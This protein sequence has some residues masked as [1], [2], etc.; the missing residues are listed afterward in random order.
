MNKAITKTHHAPNGDYI[1][2]AWDAG[3]RLAEKWFPNGINTQFGYN[4]DGTLSRVKNRRGYTDA[5]LVSQHDY[6]YDGF[7]NRIQHAETINGV[8]DITDYVYDDLMRLVTSTAGGVTN[9]Y[10]Y[11][12]LNNRTAVLTTDA[13]GATTSVYSIFDAANQ[14]TELRGG[15]A[16]GPLVGGMV[17]DANGSGRVAAQ[18]RGT[19][20]RTPCGCNLAKQCVGGVVTRSATACTGATVTAAAYDFLGRTAQI[21]KTGQPAQSYDYDDQNRRIRKTVGT[22][23]NNYLYQGEDILAEYANGWAAATG[24]ITH[25]ATTDVPLAWQPAASD[26]AGPR[27]F[28]QDG[29]G[30]IVA[31]STTA[32]T[33]D[34]ERFDAWGE[35]LV[36]S[37]AI[38]LYGYT[39]RE[40][41]GTPTT[42]TGFIYYRA[43]YY[44]PA[45]GRFTQRDPIELKGGINLY[46]YVGG[47]PVNIVDPT[48]LAPGQLFPGSSCGKNGSR[49]NFPNSVFGGDFQSACEWH[50]WCYE[51]CGV[52]QSYCDSSFRQQMM[53]ACSKISIDPYG[54]AASGCRNAANAYY[55]GVFLFGGDVYKEEQARCPCR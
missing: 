38:P 47:N 30:S 2:L 31:M 15:S 13:L 10:Q 40:Q 46:A 22:V 42:G 9:A 41:D 20:R 48:G 54:T 11:D 4:P 34:T 44:D 51:Q 19:H 32:G 28:H 5:D 17:Y 35:K 8:T 23:V 6:L 36:G 3:G 26:P 50:D 25:G 24:F 43:R 18:Q 29:L 55:V 52:S 39:G 7:R 45:N 49:Y 53:S 37:G 1:S 14:N 12:I 16:T 21:T 33:T 27:Y